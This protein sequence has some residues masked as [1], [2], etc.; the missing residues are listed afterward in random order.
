[1]CDDV[2]RLTVSGFES[3]NND[4]L[5]VLRNARRA[6]LFGN[7]APK[8]NRIYLRAEGSRTSNIQLTSNDLIGC[9]MPVDREP[10]LSHDA[11]LVSAAPAAP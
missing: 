9:E 6:L 3:P 11:V 2:D 7:R 1:V 8:G 5:L 4:P 10:G